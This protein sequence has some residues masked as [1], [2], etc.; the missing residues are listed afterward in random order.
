MPLL[1]H[2]QNS[3]DNG[4]A[5]QHTNGNVHGANQDDE[6][7]Q[8]IPELLDL[9]RNFGDDVSAVLEDNDGNRNRRLPI[10]TKSHVVATGGLHVFS[11]QLIGGNKDNE[12][13]LISRCK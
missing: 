2:P 3:G 13:K 9:L 7:Y 8:H 5:L 12:E 10:K 4:S 6:H 11:Y 1:E